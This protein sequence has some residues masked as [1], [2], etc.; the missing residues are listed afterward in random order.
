MNCLDSTKTHVNGAIDRSPG[1]GKDTGHAERF[2]FMAGKT[3]PADTMINDNLV[4]NAIPQ[5]VCHLRTE[6]GIE[7]IVKTFSLGETET[8]CP[9]VTKILEIVGIR[10]EDPEST[11]GIAE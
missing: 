11:M 3:D 10:A 8:P 6:N 7:Y 9:G 1:A 4:A 5:S 2:V